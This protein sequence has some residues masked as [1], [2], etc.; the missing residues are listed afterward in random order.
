MQSYAF[1]SHMLRSVQKVKA[2]RADDPD[3]SDLE[4]RHIFG[5]NAADE[6]AKAGARLHEDLNAVDR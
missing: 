3:L 4:R 5:N 6:A 1:A 2:H